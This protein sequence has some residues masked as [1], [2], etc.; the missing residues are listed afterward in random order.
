MIL[1]TEFDT[2]I[3]CNPSRAVMEDFS[4]RTGQA[5]EDLM[6]CDVDSMFH[7]IA[8]IVEREFDWSE[9]ITDRMGE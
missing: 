2:K 1:H 5:V 8:G 9:R 3:E 4:V 6:L 7:D